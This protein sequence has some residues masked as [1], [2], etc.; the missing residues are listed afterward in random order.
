M[1]N[2]RVLAALLALV[3]VATAIMPT[4]AFAQ[5]GGDGEDGLGEPTGPT[6]T[7]LLDGDV[8]EDFF[9]NAVTGRAYGFN[10]TAGDQVVI[11]MVSEELDPYLVLTGPYGEVYAYDDDGGE[12]PLASRIEF[13]L[14]NTGSYFIL[15]TTFGNLR[16]SFY[17]EDA[18]VEEVEMP[19]TISLS[20][21]TLPADANPDSITFFR[22]ELFVNEPF[23]DGYSTIAEPVYYF[24]LDAAAGDVLD[25]EL[26][27]EDM[28]TLL[29]VFGVG[30]VRLAADDDGGDGTNSSVLG[31]E[32]PED[33]TYVIWATSYGFNYVA[34]ATSDAD[35]PGG[36]FTLS[37]STSSAE[38]GGDK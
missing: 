3:L 23:V 20:G 31:F 8:F 34:D 11:E 30:G 36:T 7:I 38:A 17:E 35:Y 37:A 5:G 24:V 18:E 10:G 19:Y 32:V 15:A 21:A 12:E 22:G 29:M 13:T 16:G 25:I 28:D 4:A 27:S 33:G 6:L 9:T 1:K 14:P 2:L 26:V